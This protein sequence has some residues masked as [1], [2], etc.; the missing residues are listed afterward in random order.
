MNVTR[1]S[2]SKWE[3]AQSIPDLEKIVALSKLFGVT[4]DYLLK[5]EINENTDFNISDDTS[6]LKQVSLEEANAFLSSKAS[7]SKS[8]AYAVFMCIISPVFLIVL[9]AISQST[10]YAFSENVATG[11]GMILL[12]TF[13]TIAIAI[14]ISSGIKS[15]PF[16]YIEKELLE[17]QY[18]VSDMV[19]K[20]KAKYRTTYT[21]N[22][23]IGSSLCIMSLVTLFVGII[24]NEDNDLLIAVMLSISFVL[25]SIG[26]SFFIKTGII[27]ASYDKLLQEGN[28]SL[29]RK[30]KQSISAAITIT[31]W[32]TTTAIYFGYSLP[33]TNWEYSWII[34]I[35]AGILY[36]IVIVISNAIMEKK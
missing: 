4:T 33:T 19:E 28:Y 20:R 5:N 16:E 22:N 21:K 17:T 27:E 24:I 10:N 7:T 11:I 34:W 2:V 18:G 36:P 3:G 8:V 9:D 30:E 23:I 29:E 14:F 26:V 13:I 35:I 6:F 15:N 32:L 31:Y 25:V 12:L 1:Q